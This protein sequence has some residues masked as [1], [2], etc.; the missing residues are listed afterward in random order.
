MPGRNVDGGENRQQ[1]DQK[2]PIQELSQEKGEGE[3]GDKSTTEIKVEFADVQEARAAFQQSSEALNRGFGELT[4]LYNR[5][6]ELDEE[7]DKKRQAY[8]ACEQQEDQDSETL[9]QL[10][11]EWDEVH[12]ERFQLEGQIDRLDK[13]WE[14]DYLMFEAISGELRRLRN[15]NKKEGYAEMPFWKL[16]ETKADKKVL[17]ENGYV[18]EVMPK[19][20]VEDPVLAFEE[21][22]SRKEKGEDIV[23][24]ERGDNLV[25]ATKKPLESS[26]SNALTKT[27]YKEVRADHADDFTFREQLEGL[28]LENKKFEFTND[29]RLF[30]KE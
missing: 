9:R 15:E 6:N 25:I 13:E 18:I 10:A 26:A 19:R 17:D 8:D 12:K 1:D 3:T 7:W 21:I 5:F 24:I 22:H 29:K 23:I 14:K 16:H 4:S 27:G 28:L 30:V 20:F 11:L 2:D